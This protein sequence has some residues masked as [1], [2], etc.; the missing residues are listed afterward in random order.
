MFSFKLSDPIL[1]ISK[2]PLSMMP[3]AT[4]SLLGDG[5]RGEELNLLVRSGDDDSGELPRLAA[6]INAFR[7]DRELRRLCFRDLVFSFV[8]IGGGEAPIVLS[9]DGWPN[10]LEL[11][12]RSSNAPMTVGLSRDGG[13]LL[14]GSMDLDRL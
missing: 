14:F 8:S 12:G 10:P 1:N 11:E 2:R 5:V 4:G 13:R 3:P 7:S 9:L 6:A